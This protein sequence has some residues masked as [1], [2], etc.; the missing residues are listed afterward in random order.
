MQS[1]CTHRIP[2]SPAVPTEH[3]AVLLYL[4]STMQSCCTYRTACSPAV[5]TEQHAVVLYL[6]NSMQSCCTYRTSCSHAVPTEHHAVVLYLQNTMQSCCTYRT[7]CSPAVPTEHNAVLLYLQNSTQS[8]CTY[9]TPC[10]HAVPTEQYAVLLY[11]QNTMQSCC[12]YRIACDTY[13]EECESVS[14]NGS[15]RISENHTAIG[16]EDV[17]RKKWSNRK[18][19]STTMTKIQ[20][21]LLRIYYSV[22]IKWMQ[23]MLVVSWWLHDSMIC[24][25]VFGT[26]L[27]RQ[28]HVMPNQERSWRSDLLIK[29]SISPSQPLK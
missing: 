16:P 1:C 6:Q 10:S 17:K 26:D 29:C 14:L 25:D 20:L 12:T 23:A 28:S 9:R 13:R 27:H 11:Q 4:Q 15:T 3:H 2:C 8:C 7:P 5:P 21:I 22:S 24:N 18:Q 19:E